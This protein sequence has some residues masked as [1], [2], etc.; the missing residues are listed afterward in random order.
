M[1]T[2]NKTFWLTAAAA[3]MLCSCMQEAKLPTYMSGDRGLTSGVNIDN[4]SVKVVS[5]RV[6]GES[7]GLKILGFIPV[8]LASETEAVNNMYECA[9]QR[10]CPPEGY[11][12]QFVNN[13]IEKRN[14]YFI[15]ASR[16]VIRATG[17]LV[18]ILPAAQES[19]EKVSE[20]KN[21]SSK[22]A[23]KSNKRKRRR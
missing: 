10:G 16:P 2:D 5:T 22:S 9:R 21:S 18:E 23:T 12:R 4:H 7:K 13:S 14:N 6:R 11:A 20:E 8:R 17:D 19:A 15:I 1:K 3:A